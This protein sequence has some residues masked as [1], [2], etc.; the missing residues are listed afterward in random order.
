MRV[1][2]TVCAGVAVFTLTFGAGSVVGLRVN[3]SQSMPRGL[4]LVWK[5]PGIPYH[6]GDVVTACPP[7]DGWQRRYVYSGSCPTQLEPMLKPIVAVEGDRVTVSADGI[8][9]N[10]AT[11]VDSFPLNL[12]GS[13]RLLVS[14]PE[15][16][17]TVRPG[18]VWLVVPL[19]YSFD[20]RYFG[21]VSTADIQ[22][23]AKPVWVR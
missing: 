10:G 18:Q 16:N 2:G 11:I 7:L 21:P 20:S 9:V 17:Y 1:P 13:G 8:S 3:A 22:G 4:W 12:D 14:Y 23:R 6:V 15:G 19:G 5:T